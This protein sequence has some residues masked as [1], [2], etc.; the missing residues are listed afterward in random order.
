MTSRR[1]RASAW[2]RPLLPYLAAAV[3]Y[4]ALGVA[5]PR[6]LLSWAEGIAFLVVAVWAI[7]AAYGRL[8]R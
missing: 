7:P 6:V 8:R 4:I 2:V 3:V 1:G 5:E